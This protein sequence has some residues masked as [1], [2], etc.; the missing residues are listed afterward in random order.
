[1]T[2]VPPA[3]TADL[4]KTLAQALADALTGQAALRS[5]RWKRAFQTVPRHVFVPRV[6]IDP[7]HTGSYELLDSAQPGA[8]RQWLEH[9]YTDE[10]V[11]TQIDGDT[12]LSSSSQPSLMAMMLEALA[13]TGTERVLEIGTGT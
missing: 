2:Q 5:A 7:Q 12:W 11:V 4:E 6:F 1:M 10:P 3:A 13:V 8:R 9:V